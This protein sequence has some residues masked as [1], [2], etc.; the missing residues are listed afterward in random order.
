MVETDGEERVAREGQALATRCD[1]DDA[2][3]RRVPAGQLCDHARRH[4]ALLVE[5]PDLVGI[6][7]D[8]LRSGLAQN[9]GNGVRHRRLVEVRSEEHTS[10]L[11]SLM[12]NSYA[13][14]CLENKKQI[15]NK[16]TDIC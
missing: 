8:E 13:V 5:G 12:R 1:M 14:F 11:Q 6:G 15:K 10:E 16:Y 2:V 9:L 4:F 7:I 3:P